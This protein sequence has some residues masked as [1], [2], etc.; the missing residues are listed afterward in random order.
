MPP[1]GPQ[2]QRWTGTRQARIPEPDGE[3]VTVRYT[4]RELLNRWTS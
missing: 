3:T 2:A 1:A 4:L